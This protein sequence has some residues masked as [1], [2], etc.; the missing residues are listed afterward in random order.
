[1]RVIRCDRCSEEVSTKEARHVT[2]H[3]DQPGGND[4]GWDFCEH[5]LNEIL[6]WITAYKEKHE[7]H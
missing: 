4:E 6:E 5:C 1:M 7:S 2:V 3:Q